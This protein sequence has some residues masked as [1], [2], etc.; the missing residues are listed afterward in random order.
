MT[1]SCYS[2]AKTSFFA[3]ACRKGYCWPERKTPPAAE[4]PTANAAAMK[5]VAELSYLVL[6]F[7]HQLW[8]KNQY[9][10]MG[11]SFSF[12]FFPSPTPTLVPVQVT[13]IAPLVG[14]KR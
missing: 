6:L 9:V 8:K 5:P 7:C 2:V 4:K 3:A 1:T 11:W 14:C 13:S 10:Q 12:F